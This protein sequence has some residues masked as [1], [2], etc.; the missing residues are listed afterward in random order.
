M[1]LISKSLMA[2]LLFGIAFAGNAWGQ[3]PDRPN[4]GSN[5]VDPLTLYSQNGTLQVALTLNESTDSFGYVHYCYIYNDNGTMVEAP[6]LQLD[7]GDTLIMDITN[8]LSP[9]AST[10]DLA[11]AIDGMDMTTHK[12]A[13]SP[14][15]DCNG[16]TVTDHTT[17]VHFH[18]LNVPPTCHQDD[19]IYTLIQPGDPAFE[20][21]I[22]IPPSD[23]P[24]M[25]WYHPHPHGFATIQVNGGASGAIIIGGTNGLNPD[26]EGLKARQIIMRQQFLTGPWLAGPNQLTINF[27]VSAPPN[28]LAPVILMN[29]GQ[30][31][32]WRV[33]NASSQAFLALQVWYGSTP[34]P[35]ELI[36]VDGVPLKEK[37]ILTTIHMFPAGR[38]EFIVKAPPAG[39]IA[40]LQTVNFQTGPIGNPTIP[41]KIAD[42]NLT[43]DNLKG[44]AVMPSVSKPALSYDTDELARLKPTTQRNLYFS[45]S[46]G[47]VNGPNN[48]YITVDG[49]RPHQ[50]QVNEPPAIKTTVGAVEDWT[51]ENRAL[52]D[53]AFHIHQVHFLV[54][55]I[56]GKPVAE[57]FFADTF[58]VHAWSGFGAYHSI[59]VRM[60]FRHPGIAGTF[61]YH[62]H[63][64]EHEDLGMMAK[65]EVD[66]K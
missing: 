27:Q 35:L 8:A 18:G 48:Y 23:P 52:E 49:Q 2:V 59:T 12:P 45:E 60:D 19:V 13:G 7:P 62:C 5:V 55:A 51:I 47:G 14:A 1:R 24:G 26:V 3:C 25:Y 33:V 37:R 29:S 4:T 32:F 63:V 53:H 57:P 66:P 61:V 54:M 58:F 44:L 22:Q 46:A 64:L 65:I 34:Q 21:K 9:D 36:S 42:I 39:V 38:D 40:T 30:N 6:S 28:F 17:N 11:P 20:Y 41:Q 56:D 43:Q 16:G 50:F 15:S 10:Q 31:Q